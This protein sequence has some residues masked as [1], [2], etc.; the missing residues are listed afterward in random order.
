MKVSELQ[1]QKLNDEYIQKDISY[2][3]NI[4][5]F[6]IKDNTTWTNVY[7]VLFSYENDLWS[8]DKNEIGKI[9]ISKCKN[10]AFVKN[11]LVTIGG[12]CY[13]NNDSRY[14]H[15]VDERFVRGMDRESIICLDIFAGSIDFNNG[16]AKFEIEMDDLYQKY[17]DT[18]NKLYIK[19]GNDIVGPFTLALRNGDSYTIKKYLNSNIKQAKYNADY[20]F[21]PEQD[22]YTNYIKRYF[23]L[24]EFESELFKG[25][26]DI[27]FISNFSLIEWARS[28]YE[29][30][31]SQKSIQ[32][33][34]ISLL[35]QWIDKIPDIKKATNRYDRLNLIKES[36]GSYDNSI[37]K[38]IELIPEVKIIRDEITAIEADKTRLEGE[39]SKTDSSIADLKKSQG[40]EQDA[41]DKLQ[42]EIAELETRKSEYQ[43]ELEEKYIQQQQELIQEIDRLTQERDTLTDTLDKERKKKQEEIQDEINKLKIKAGVI[44]EQNAELE[45]TKSK[46][47]KEFTDAQSEANKILSDL[48]KSKTHFDF[49]RGKKFS[50]SDEF[51]YKYEY[52]VPK[53]TQAITT[54]E[55]LRER[56]ADVLKSQNRKYEGHFIDN[57]LITTTQNLFTLFVGLPGTGKTSMARIMSKSLSGGGR[58]AEVS[59]GRGWTSYKDLLGF[60]NPLSGKFI[61]SHK[62]LLN[63]LRDLDFESRNNTSDNNPLLYVVLD[64]ANLSPIEHYWSIF[65]N[66]TDRDPNSAFEIDL[67]DG[68]KF[69][70][71]NA[72]R[73][74]GTINN[75]HT[76]EKISPRIL[77]RANLIYFKPEDI[78]L[79]GAIEQIEELYVTKKILADFILDVNSDENN[80]ASDARFNNQKETYQKI[81]KHLREE[82]QIYLSP[83]IDIAMEK[84]CQVANV[85]MKEERFRPLDYFVAQRVLPLIN[86]NG[87]KENLE[88]LKEIIL[89][90]FKLRKSVAGE[91]LDQ[92]IKRGEAQ[93]NQYDYF[94]IVGY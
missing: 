63:K 66:D 32:K 73:F 50:D 45:T 17:I 33:D 67:G 21:E 59:V 16:T 55:K 20:I 87:N 61:E 47:Q 52:T 41:L 76:T 42:S 68:G 1:G 84:Y 3:D 88:K 36:L 39:K 81:K 91:I 89:E 38:F 70:H 30:N 51:I 27:D 25:S 90:D 93:Y 78:G 57:L 48:V 11:E 80:Y 5:I 10:D 7:P 53:D 79:L 75:D 8:I 29:K 82:M 77:D 94:S 44:R 62:D 15:F 9:C 46:L 22:E 40:D 60:Y 23:L 74:I 2:R 35:Y 19:D 31:V 34:A 49:I 6:A 65:I 69:K 64:E 37:T 54:Y 71:S 58:T 56:F 83:R 85:Y 28:E 14:S 92:I 4:F 13:P 26:I 43:K 86:Y 12:R 24:E 18:Q 72:I